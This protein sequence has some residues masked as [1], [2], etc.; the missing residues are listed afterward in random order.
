MREN[1]KRTHVV[2]TWEGDAGL[3]AVSPQLPGFSYGRPTRTEFI[4]DYKNVLRDAGVLGDVLGHEQR[5]FASPEG[6]EYVIRVAEDEHH[7][8]RTELAWRLEA[9]LE[10]EQRHDLLNSATNPMGEVTYIC[11]VATDTLGWVSEQMDPRG[12]AVRVA[13]AV[14]DELV[15]TTQFATAAEQPEGW[16]TMEDRGWTT[17]TTVGEVCQQLAAGERASVL[18]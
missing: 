13:L 9:A 17:E 12:D 14:A 11:C 5:R 7:A 4:T 15:W 2:V 16:A 8:E 10:T 1:G 18:V 6:A 3:S